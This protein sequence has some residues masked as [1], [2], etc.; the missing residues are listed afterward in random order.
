MLVA[1]GCSEKKLFQSRRVELCNCADESEAGAGRKNASSLVI[2]TSMIFMPVAVH[3]PSHCEFTMND[4]VT[5]SM[6]KRAA[7]T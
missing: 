7:I 1:I 5:I 4:C 2:A 6:S 3:K